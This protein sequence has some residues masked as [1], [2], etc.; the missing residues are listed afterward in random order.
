MLTWTSKGAWFA[1]V[2]QK[3]SVWLEFL[4]ERKYIM[5]KCSKFAFYFVTKMELY[6][7]W[8]PRKPTRIHKF[9]DLCWMVLLDHGTFTRL[10]TAFLLGNNPGGGTDGPTKIEVIVILGNTF[11][12]KSD[13]RPWSLNLK[14]TNPNLNSK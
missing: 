5:T 6:K 9:H 2:D 12:L 10:T 7:T 11:L 1:F 8:T 13:N 3:A 14:L 4:L